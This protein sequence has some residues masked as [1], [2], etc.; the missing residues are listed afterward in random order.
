MSA[1]TDNGPIGP[2]FTGPLPT[3]LALFS[4]LLQ[5]PIPLGMYLLLT[6]GEHVLRCDVADGTIQADVVV[7]LDVALYLT[8]RILQR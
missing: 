6:P 1:T 5:L 3:N 4:R 8:P 7:V 2:F